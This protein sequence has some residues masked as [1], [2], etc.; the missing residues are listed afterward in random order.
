M[1]ATPGTIYLKDYIPPAYLAESIALDVDF[2]KEGG[3]IVAFVAAKI[4]FQANPA[5]KG[6]RGRMLLHGEA[7]ETLRFTVA[8]AETNFVEVAE[9]RELQGLPEQFTLNTLVKVYPDK[10]TR[11]SGLYRSQN[12]YFTQCEAEGFRRIT[13]FPDRPDVMTR[14]VVTIHADKQVF[15]VLLSNGNLI[16]SGEEGQ[17]RHYAVWQDPFRKP[18]Y[19]FALV[20]ARLDVLEGSFVTAGGRKVDLGIYVEPGRLDQCEHAMLAL[21]KAMRWD[22]ERFGLECDL[23]RYMIVAVSDFN[24]GAMEN[25]GLNIF[26]AKYV[27]AKPEVATD[28]DFAGIE[29]VVA[30]E[31]FHNWTGNRVTC[32]DWFQL[33]LKEGL[34][35][36]RDQEFGADT[37]DSRIARIREVRG[38]FAAQFPEDAG[39]MAH[40]VRP[41]SYMEINNF[42]TATVYEKGAEVVRMIETMIG[43][44][45]FRAG[46]AEYFA[47]HD[48]EAVTCEDFV[49]AMADASG[50]ALM[51]SFL[52]WYSAPGTPRLSVW[53]EFD[54]QTRRYT[55]TVEQSNPKAVEIQGSARPCL[56]PLKI[57][58]FDDTGTEISGSACCLIVEQAKQKF[59]FEAIE[60]KPVPS[61][62]RAFSAPVVLDYAYTPR[63]LGLLAVCESDPFAAWNTGQRLACDLILAAAREKRACSADEAAVFANILQTLLERRN[64]RGNAFVAE[65]MT[66]P[67]EIALA[68][69]LAREGEIDPD[70]LRAARD[71]L[72]YA[73]A[74]H[75]EAELLA[76]YHDLAPEGSYQFTA[77]AAGRRALRHI[78]L[79]YLLELEKPVYRQLALRQYRE[80]DN[81][82]D[83]FAALAALA[84]GKSEVCPEREEA[85][86]AFYA[87][88][89]HEPLVLDKW[90][91]AQASGR[92]PD[93]L[94]VVEKLS[95]HSAFEG[96]NPNRI[97][98]LFRTFGANLPHFHAADGAG[99][100]FMIAEILALDERNPQVAA[101]IARAFEQW[102]K[103]DATRRGHA[104]TALADALAKPAGLSTDLYEVLARIL[105]RA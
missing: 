84:Y 105:G 43:R 20:A 62:L 76:L 98:A 37:H 59:V 47:R 34:T 88:W 58:L 50:F 61:L 67:A 69:M 35:V 27:L 85:L 55:L 12:G 10:N 83:R 40:P 71:S 41:D 45:A 56:I 94:A 2:Q 13:W 80:A 4:I 16:E 57:A 87:D 32:R 29:R 79:A 91:A 70:A 74:E 1:T 54:S 82:T 15:P 78:C 68:E 38:L 11:L 24:M 26:N 64:E 48:G 31:Y 104:R 21:K 39:P 53:T 3:E 101:R 52:N 14:F 46:L 23:E 77:I 97:Y 22:E 28:S 90:L 65:I 103:F 51:G 73:L 63:E 95:R 8:E 42:Y 33:S 17:G 102:Q 81:M 92:R 7:L 86:T 60:R 36:F 72:R 9:G 18:C 19:L 75:L 100:R 44:D 30:H 99:Y 49:A 93:T 96:N 66:L 6:E 25:K 89:Q 5:H